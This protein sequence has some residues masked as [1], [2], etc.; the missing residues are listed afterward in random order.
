MAEKS[1]KKTPVK[2]ELSLEDQLA[3]KRAELM[4]LRK[5]HAAGELVNPRAITA[6]KKDIARLLTSI[7]QGKEA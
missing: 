6:A 5:S 2:K 1:T 4:D 7:N 3:A